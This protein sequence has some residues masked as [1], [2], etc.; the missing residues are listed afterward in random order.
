MASLLQAQTNTTVAA[1][2][3]EMLAQAAKAAGLGVE[4]MKPVDGVAWSLQTRRHG[5]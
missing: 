1:A 3:E 2:V 4:T 5:W